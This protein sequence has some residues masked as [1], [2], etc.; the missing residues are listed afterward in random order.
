MS[1]RH[2]KKKD[3]KPDGGEKKRIRIREH[4]VLKNR[5][6]MAWLEQQIENDPDGPLAKEFLNDL[7]NRKEWENDYNIR[8]QRI[9]TLKQNVAR[10]K[11]T[12][13]TKELKKNEKA[14]KALMGGQK[15]WRKWI[16]SITAGVIG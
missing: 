8:V 14:L 2:D 4:N 16:R 1:H 9:A 12:D 7:N 10:A 3:Y 6:K 13:N 11:T 5:E 15:L